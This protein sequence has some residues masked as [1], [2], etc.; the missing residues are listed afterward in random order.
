[1]A[2][3][4]L[5][6]VLLIPPILAVGVVYAGTGS[7]WFDASRA[8]EQGRV[9]EWQD[10]AFTNRR[11]FAMW[12]ESTGKDYREWAKRHRAAAA[13]LSGHGQRR[14]ALARRARD[15]RDSASSPP[16]ATRWGRSALLALAAGAAALL[17]I[18]VVRRLPYVPIRTVSVAYG[19]G[20]I[21]F[22]VT[23]AASAERRLAARP[24]APPVSI[25]VRSLLT[26]ITGNAAPL[27]RPSSGGVSASTLRPVRT[28]RAAARLARPLTRPR[29]EKDDGRRV[30][31]AIGNS[32]R[33]AVAFALRVARISA[34]R[35]A[36]LASDEL[37]RH[38][39]ADVVFALLGLALAVAA[40][41]FLPLVL[42]R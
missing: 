11:G 36:T 39:R 37:A 42:T 30:A 32:A 21:R 3:A 6:S 18:A 19:A 23:S 33:R 2:V 1:V 41:V 7:V 15:D 28:G 4:R 26:A 24:R 29:W 35:V 25:R 10:R 16:P 27:V 34:R 13:R 9:V 17:A 22:L 20:A 8:R 5:L 31:A 38:N 40:G 12:L 14:G